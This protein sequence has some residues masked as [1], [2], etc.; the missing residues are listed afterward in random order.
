MGV[1]WRC[2]WLWWWWEV[3]SHPFFLFLVTAWQGAL[4]YFMLFIVLTFLL[5]CLPQHHQRALS[6]RAHSPLP[7]HTRVRCVNCQPGWVSLC[8]PL[9]HLNASQSCPS[10]SQCDIC[11]SIDVRVTVDAIFSC[12]CDDKEFHSWKVILVNILWLRTNPFRSAPLTKACYNV[13]ISFKFNGSN[14]NNC[15]CAYQ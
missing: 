14:G 7:L 2:V 10:L 6:D 1:E 8:H 4:P 15:S 5:D 3:W 11:I 13:C 12:G 9:I